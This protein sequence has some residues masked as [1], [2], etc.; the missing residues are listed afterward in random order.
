MV[1]VS[2]CSCLKKD[3]LR[4]YHYK[5]SKVSNEL[6]TN[7]HMKILLGSFHLNGHTLGF[8]PQTSK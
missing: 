5:S 6:N 7:Y 2:G 1:E 8:H 3:K 4:S